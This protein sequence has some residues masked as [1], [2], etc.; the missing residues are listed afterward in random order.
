MAYNVIV[1][2]KGGSQQRL[3]FSKDSVLI[4]RVHGNDVV[5]PRGNVSKQHSK[6]QLT[7]G[8]FTVTDLESTNGTYI[9]GR[10]IFT[11]QQITTK[12]KIY[13]GD[14]ILHVEYGEA[15]PPQIPK[16]KVSKP[17][18]T[19]GD[20]GRDSPPP[21]PISTKKEEITERRSRP[22]VPPPMPRTTE[23]PTE[24]RVPLPSPSAPPKRPVQ[25]RPS[26]DGVV[27]S[28]KSKVKPPAIR[29]S[30]AP[31]VGGVK[32]VQSLLAQALETLTLPEG[33]KGR[34][35][36]DTAARAR[37]VVGRGVDTFV[38]ESGGALTKPAG[39]LKGMVYRRIVDH[40]P[41][42]GWVEDPRVINIRAR[43]RRVVL[44]T[45]GGKQKRIEDGFTGDAQLLEVIDALSAGIDV[46]ESSVSGTRRWFTEEGYQAFASSLRG[47]H[48]LIIDKTV[49]SGLEGGVS[50]AVDD[51]G[52][53]VIR[54]A[55]DSDAKIAVL[56]KSPLARQLVFYHL[57]HLL[58]AQGLTVVLE[59]LPFPFSA[60]REWIQL[61]MAPA[62]S[63]GGALSQG[64][65]LEPG[66][67]TVGGVSGRGVP[68]IISAATGRIGLIA[69]LPLSALGPIDRELSVVMTS[70]GSP[71]S[72]GEAAAL[73]EEAF[74]I[75]IIANRSRLGEVYI[76]EISA[77]AVSDGR[78]APNALFDAKNRK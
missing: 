21:P 10:R 17:V 35:D 76:K 14:F 28:T 40:G 25:G 43:G 56:G 46:M 53:E 32:I 54:S 74:D 38:V 78:W 45:I 58:P 29:K 73:L 67:L 8:V 34:V 71:V 70:S 7:D 47:D 69:D 41:L 62:S 2:E 57:L 19:T 39:V 44:S 5:L 12:D 27:S 26:K 13:V 30:E 68:E 64:L 20:S 50:E 55:I 66:W 51:A 11:P 72:A 18:V 24:K 36:P 22:S 48:T 1:T 6:L 77:S 3:E 65:A 9:N 33:L 4:G 60:G 15:Q 49:A 23:N 37:Q 75:I 59:P 16:E 42:S 63:G 61:V 31:T 52:L